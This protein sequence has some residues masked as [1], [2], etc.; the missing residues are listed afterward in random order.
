M[1]YA[2]TRYG[3]HTLKEV[4]SPCRDELFPVFTWFAAVV[5]IH[6]HWRCRIFHPYKPERVTQYWVMIPTQDLGPINI[7]NIDMILELGLEFRL[8]TMQESNHHVYWL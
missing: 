7:I 6:R 3:T 5:L 8:T 1:S 2:Q 4:Q